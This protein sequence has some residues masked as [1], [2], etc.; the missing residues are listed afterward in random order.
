MLFQ[1]IKNKNE[2]ISRLHQTNAKNYSMKLQLQ[3]NL[4]VAK[5]LIQGV[6]LRIVQQQRSG[7]VVHQHQSNGAIQRTQASVG[8]AIKRY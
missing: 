4:D 3:R 2:I 1:E 6:H 8:G 5:K 7:V